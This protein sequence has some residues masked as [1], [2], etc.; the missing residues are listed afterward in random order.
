MVDLAQIATGTQSAAN[1]L[2]LDDQLKKIL[3]KS[4][5][6]SLS[7]EKKVG[8]V[9]IGSDSVFGNFPP[10]YKSA[11]L[12]QNLANQRAAAKAEYAAIEAAS[13][14]CAAERRRPITTT[15]FRVFYDRGDLPVKVA[16]TKGGGKIDWRTPMEKL[17]Y[18]H[19]LP[20][21]FDGLREKEDPYRFLAV[22][23]CYDLLQSAR[24]DQDGGVARLLPV[25]PQLVIPV[26]T[27]MTTRDPELV[28][29]VMKVLQALVFCGGESTLI[30]ECL[31]PY[32]RQIL[33][34]FNIYKDHNLNIG[35]QMDYS[36]RKRKVLGE[37]VLETLEVFEKRGGE[38]A[39]INIKYMVPTYE[40]CVLC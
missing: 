24:H 31:V 35:D 15:L 25:V 12:R 8:L 7:Y 37:L 34:V 2:L 22:Q 28:C 11:S 38:D 36:Q 23:G 10:N 6:S 4:G 27:T 33:P 39:F 9:P 5:R 3:D 29:T 21:F 30:G 32:Y 20:I 17:D 40:S 19:Y 13:K 16:H 14:K 18:N 26:K 1:I